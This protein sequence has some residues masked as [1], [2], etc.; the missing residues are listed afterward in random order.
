MFTE[1]LNPFICDSLAHLVS[2]IYKDKWGSAGNCMLVALR[3]FLICYV[4]NSFWSKFAKSRVFTCLIGI[5]FTHVSVRSFLTSSWYS[6]MLGT[7]T[8]I[9][10]STFKMCNTYRDC[11]VWRS[12]RCQWDHWDRWSRNDYSYNHCWGDE[13]EKELAKLIHSKGAQRRNDF[14]SAFTGSLSG[15]EVKA[16]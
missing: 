6:S 12:R 14:F 5:R 16:P 11:Q 13:Q 9:I 10:F 7:I 8:E 1:I 3:R 15:W 2:H 4:N